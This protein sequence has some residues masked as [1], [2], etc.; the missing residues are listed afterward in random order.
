ML[1]PEEKNEM[2]ANTSHPPSTWGGYREASPLSFSVFLT[3]PFQMWSTKV[4][5]RATQ[6]QDTNINSTCRTDR[7]AKTSQSVNKGNLHLKWLW[8]LSSHCQHIILWSYILLE[9]VQKLQ[10]LIL[11]IYLINIIYRSKVQVYSDWF[12]LGYLLW[13]DTKTRLNW[14]VS[15]YYLEQICEWRCKPLQHKLNLSPQFLRLEFM[16]ISTKI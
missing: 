15:V 4:Q 14:T 10:T 11:V 6:G 9:A 16:T 2:P 7:D 3:R 5:H 13:H 8:T 12:L 1:F